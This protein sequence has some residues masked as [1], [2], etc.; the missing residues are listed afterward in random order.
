MER[1]HND[2]VKSI[3]SRVK[4]LEEGIRAKSERHR[5]ELLQLNELLEEKDRR[6]EG[7]EESKK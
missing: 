6:I 4:E 2:E 5:R 7:I 3:Q 1:L